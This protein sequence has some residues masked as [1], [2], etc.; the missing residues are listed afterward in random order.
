MWIAVS[1]TRLRLFGVP[2]MALP[3]F[4]Y[5]MNRSAQFRWSMPAEAAGPVNGPV[6]PIVAL[7]HDGPAAICT[8]LPVFA[9]ATDAA[10]A[11]TP[12]TITTPRIAG[13]FFMPSSLLVAP[14][15]LTE[16]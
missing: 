16:T 9:T 5:W 6:T 8:V 12:R 10:A 15:F 1:G 11:A 13:S 3:P 14:C 4:Q 7:V 2:G